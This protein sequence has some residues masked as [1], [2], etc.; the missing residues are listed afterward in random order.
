MSWHI[1]LVT[2]TVEINKQIAKDLATCG[3]DITYTWESESEELGLDILDHVGLFFDEDS[4]LLIFNDDHM[5]HMDYISQ[6]E[7][8]DVL[9][10]HKVKG[11]IGFISHEG[12][13]QGEI[14]G[15][16][17]DGN[18]GCEKVD[19][20]I[21]FFPKGSLIKTRRHRSKKTS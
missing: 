11:T 19:G 14:W 9:C 17:F 2:N 12:D 1:K 6:Q 4:K 18:G 20:A 3:A 16:V 5:E 13:N 8:Q 10:A 7:V 15:Y 21:G